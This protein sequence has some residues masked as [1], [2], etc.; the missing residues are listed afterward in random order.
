MTKQTFIIAFCI[1]IMAT[2]GY[3]AMPLFVVMTDVHG[4]TLVQVGLLSAV[5]IFT[6]KVTPI[7]FGP[8]GDTIGHR[9][10]ACTG[11]FLRGMG[12]IGLGLFNPFALLLISTAIAGIGGGVAGPSLKAL[13]ML[14]ADQQHRPKISALRSTA[15]NLA[16]VIGPLLAGLV[17]FFG[18]LNG[19]F[20]TAGICYLLGVGLILFFS[21]PL[22]LSNGTFSF[23]IYKEIGFNSKFIHLLIYMFFVW[24]LFAQLFVTIPD[25][26]QLFTSHIEQF[27][28]INGVMGILFEF[29]LG[30]IMSKSN[31]PSMFLTCGTLLFFLSF[32]VFG[33]VHQLAGLYLGIIL[34]TVGELLIF[35]MMETMVANLAADNKNMAAYF[36]ISSISD[37]LGRP[38]GSF[39]GGLLFEMIP[40][41]S[42]GWYTLS[43]IG[44]GL[45]FYYVLF[46][47]KRI[48][49]IY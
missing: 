26:A 32:L 31:R 35:P 27:F 39:F 29:P 41:P 4:I 1:F 17:I 44:C 16:L 36:G 19:I 46:L 25:Y 14:S 38:A 45:W 40:H 30:Y 12:F 13:I 28:L 10:M 9:K 24:L 21:H 2:G 8:I 7:L 49:S 20:I 34:F 22:P 37:G 11:E 3:T 48:F 6:Q 23:S 5:Y 47:R 33:L 42:L 15:V 18:Y 43:F